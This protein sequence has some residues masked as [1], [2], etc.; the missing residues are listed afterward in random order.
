MCEGDDYWTDKYKLQKQVDFLEANSDYAICFHKVK[1]QKGN[2]LLDD[3]ITR[4]PSESTTIA[5][6]AKENY[7]HT[8]SVMFRAGLLLPEWFDK[9]LA[10]DYALHLLNAL[11]GKIFCINQLMAVYRIHDGGM[12]STKKEEENQLRWIEVLNT[13]C[14]HF[15]GEAGV[16]LRKQRLEWAMTL[17]EKGFHDE[18]IPVLRDSVI[19]LLSRC[20]EKETTIQ[21]LISDPAFLEEKVSGTVLTKALQRKVGKLLK[22]KK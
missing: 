13:L 11:R 12:W 10:G 19:Q 18:T 1:L 14:P 16:I 20:R 6:L 4:P 7:I 22:G 5:D 3:Y 21:K 2:E 15:E 17:F 8:P 9:V